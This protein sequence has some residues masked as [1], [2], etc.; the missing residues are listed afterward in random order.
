MFTL[1]TSCFYVYVFFVAFP[2]VDYGLP[3][4]NFD[5][6]CGVLLLL[7]G[8]GGTLSELCCRCHVSALELYTVQLGCIEFYN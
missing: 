8:V 3:C 5:R 7:L 2:L 4:S 6:L 1:A